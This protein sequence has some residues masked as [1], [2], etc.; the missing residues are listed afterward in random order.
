[1]NSE[2]GTRKCE[3]R[4]D[5]LN[6][7]GDTIIKFST[8]EMNRVFNL[9]DRLA[10]YSATVLKLCNLLPKTYAADVIAKQLTRAGVSVALNYGEAQSAESRKDFIHKVKISLKEARESYVCLKIINLSDIT[11]QND[12][13]S[14]LLKEAN[15]IISILVKSVETAK[16]NMENNK[17]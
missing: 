11:D 2:Q 14:S 3:G 7:S 15:E 17:E 12:L 16:K 4:F 13:L 5:L 1:M 10:V 6:I 9:E 8:A